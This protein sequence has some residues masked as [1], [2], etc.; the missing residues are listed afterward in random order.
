LRGLAANFGAARLMH[1]LRE[2]EAA[3]TQGDRERS[4][5]LMGLASDEKVQLL[6]ALHAYCQ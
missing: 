1:R 4:L 6:E 3:L 2:L 5:A